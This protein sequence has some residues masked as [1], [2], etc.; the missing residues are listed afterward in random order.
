MTFE[1]FL[2]Q[3][4]ELRLWSQCPMAGEAQKY[5]KNGQNRLILPILVARPK[6]LDLLAFGSVDQRSIPPQL[7]AH[8]TVS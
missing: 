1:I 3:I 4:L 5:K 2:E 7:R 8:N 6:R